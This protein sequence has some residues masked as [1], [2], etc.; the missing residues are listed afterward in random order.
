[1]KNLEIYGV[2]EISDSLKTSTQ[3]GTWLGE[4]VGK[5]LGAA[6]KYSGPYGASYFLVDYTISQM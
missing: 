4:A 1:M 2:Q 6:A 5:F 3:G